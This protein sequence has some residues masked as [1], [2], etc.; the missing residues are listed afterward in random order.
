[1]I[2][3]R[4]GSGY[5]VYRRRELEQLR[6]L[7]D[8]R[9]RFGLELTELAFVARLRRE[10]VLRAAVEGW[11]ATSAVGDPASPN[12]AWVDWEQRKQE[13]LLAA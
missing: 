12:V 6:R 1:V 4:T 8:L 5:R 10:P 9:R 7:A 2:P 11:F 13:R 3:A